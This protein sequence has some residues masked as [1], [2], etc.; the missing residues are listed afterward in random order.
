MSDASNNSISEFSKINYINISEIK[1]LPYIVNTPTYNQAIYSYPYFD[2]DKTQFLW[3]FPNGNKELNYIFAVPIDCFFYSK[4]KIDIEKDLF[5]DFFDILICKYSYTFAKT[6]I[7]SIAHDILNLSATFEKYFIFLNYISVAPEKYKDVL[8]RTEIEYFFGVIRSLYDLLQILI[9]HFIKHYMKKDL[10]ESYARMFVE[11]TCKLKQDYDYLP[12]QLRNYYNSSA[13]LFFKCRDI[14]DKIYHNG[15]TNSFIT[16]SEEGFGIDRNL[17]SFSDFDIWP[18]DKVKE[19]NIVS[20]LALFSYLT[21]AVI[22]NMNEL[23]LALLGAF[24]PKNPLVSNDYMILLRGSCT[25]H[26]NKLN[27]Y[28]NEQWILQR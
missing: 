18:Q 15:I 23:A 12:Q 21:K 22:Q 14:R 7:D 9:K 3:K 16:Y 8:I 27:E 5:I 13:Y 2:D 10:K 24:S 25:A 26:L 19:N 28:L 20:L 4:S 6:S 1:K 11:D 17:F